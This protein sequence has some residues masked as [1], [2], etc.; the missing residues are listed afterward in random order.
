M[1]ETILTDCNIKEILNEKSF[2]EVKFWF[3]GELNFPHTPAYYKAI[4][5]V[6]DIRVQYLEGS[7]PDELYSILKKK[8][9]RI[10]CL[11]KLQYCE[12]LDNVI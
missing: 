5:V 12:G 6:N 1:F 7:N 10:S 9:N 3:D 2:I 8:Y 11:K 4:L